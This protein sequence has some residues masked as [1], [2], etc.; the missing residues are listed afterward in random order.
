MSL[1][2]AEHLSRPPEVGRRYLVKV[3]KAGIGF[4]RRG[5]WWPVHGPEHTDLEIGGA[6]FYRHYHLFIPF[7]TDYQV[8][9]LLYGQYGSV[10]IGEGS[11]RNS[12]VEEKWMA[13]TCARLWP[14]FPWKETEQ[15]RTAIAA[16]HKPLHPSCRTCPHRGIN[17]A[18]VPP[19]AEGRITCPGHGLRWHAATGEPAP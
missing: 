8:D 18:L 3:V 19:D 15:M 11:F 2:I 10:A 16:Y 12:F 1:Q 9:G 13:R 6:G 14:S 4:S 5:L 17:L 7:L